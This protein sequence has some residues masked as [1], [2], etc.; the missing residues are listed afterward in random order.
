MKKSNLNLYC[1][2]PPVMIATFAIEIGL[3]AYA[4]WRYKLNP[5][6]RLAIAILVCL[7]AFQLAEFNV[8]EGSWIDP[9]VASRLGYV[10]ITALPPLGLHLIATIAGKPK[11]RLVL[12]AYITGAAFA[13]YFLVSGWLD[14]NVCAGNYVIFQVSSGTELLYGL[15][16]YG[17]MLIS[18][19]LAWVWGRQAEPRTRQALYGM[20]AGYAAFILPT[21]AVNMVSQETIAGIPSIMC[22][23]AVLFAL[24][25]ALWVLPRAGEK[26]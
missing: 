22:G 15:Y 1:F 7:A 2:S 26:K 8:C 14:G 17:W 18:V 6:S 11:H 3:A 5:V 12:P 10:A 20:A 9:Q 4:L 21:T 16:Y 19:W 25:L 24:V 23:F 13:V